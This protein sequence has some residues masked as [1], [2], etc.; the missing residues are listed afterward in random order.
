MCLTGWKTAAAVWL[1]AG[2]LGAGAGALTRLESAAQRPDGE[3]GGAA[4]PAGQ[5]PTAEK[6]K[7]PKLPALGEEKVKALLA[8][9]KVGDKM[10]AL[11]KARLEAA[12]KEAEGRRQVYREGESGTL[13]DLASSSL[14]LLEA[15]RELS[16]QKADQIAALENHWQRMKELEEINQ[17]RFKA[18]RVSVMD[19]SQARF[20]RLQAEIWL[21][22]AKA[23]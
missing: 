4:G 17:E 19:L 6:G 11:L 9:A 12:L 3:R 15:E 18:G 23:R 10:K 5:Q 20:Y 13:N 16:D 22:R 7:R 1:S 2:V 21:E 14:R 8:A